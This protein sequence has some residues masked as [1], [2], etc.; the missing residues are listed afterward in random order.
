MAEVMV[1]P[2]QTGGAHCLQPDAVLV[3]LDPAHTAQRLTD[4]VVAEDQAFQTKPKK[5]RVH[6]RRLI[7]HV[8]A[9]ETGH[10]IRTHLFPTRLHVR[11]F[12]IRCA[13]R[14]A[15]REAIET[16]HLRAAC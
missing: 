4:N 3:H 9:C 16:V 2:A 5:R 10:N 8:A 11:Q 12:G 7:D 15:A 1:R 6:A 14:R 13:R